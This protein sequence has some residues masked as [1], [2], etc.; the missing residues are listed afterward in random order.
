[1]EDRI[2][3]TITRV[4]HANPFKGGLPIHP[5][6]YSMILNTGGFVDDDSW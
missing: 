3:E 1:M 2:L 4:V 5:A 6:L